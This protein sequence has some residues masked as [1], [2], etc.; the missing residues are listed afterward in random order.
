M[1]ASDDGQLDGRS[2]WEAMAPGWKERHGYFESAAGPVTEAM[3]RKASPAPGETVLDLA[4]GTGVVGLAAARG[5]GP[6]GQA[7]IS[8]FVPDMVEA[9]RRNADE[10][11]MDNVDC[12]VLDAEQ[13]DLDDDSVDVV[14]CRWGYMLM[15]N[16]MRALAESRRVLTQGG[17]LSCAVFGGPGE[18]PWAALPMRVLVERGLA[19]PPRPDAPGTLALADRD[20]LRTLLTDVGFSTVE[21][22]DVPFSW[23]FSDGASYW[24]FLTEAAGA[25]ALAIERLERDEQE[26]VHEDLLARLEPYVTE[27]GMELPA[28]AVVAAAS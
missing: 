2:V 11:G 22:V 13:L 7:I 19:S 4:A 1:V 5:V 25:V 20:R 23:P 24:K 21:I 10:L 9:A 17:R 8:D 3:L 27:E 16:P 6:Q 26:Q 18:N 15:P 14:L 28:V 12:R